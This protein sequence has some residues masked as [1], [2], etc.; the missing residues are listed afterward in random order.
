MNKSNK[1]LKVCDKI[2][3]IKGSPEDII[4]AC[5]IIAAGLTHEHSLDEK[6]AIRQFKTVYKILEHPIYIKEEN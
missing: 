4:Y 3:K 6:I 5:M 1:V 2:S